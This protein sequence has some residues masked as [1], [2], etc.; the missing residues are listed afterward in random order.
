MF[1]TDPLENVSGLGAKKLQALLRHFGGK[2]GIKFA[3]IED[4]KT[5]PGIGSSLAERIHDSLHG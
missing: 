2:K 1:L 4:L 3:S 5:V